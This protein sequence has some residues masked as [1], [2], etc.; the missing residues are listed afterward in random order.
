ML[1][2]LLHYRHM[3]CPLIS[4]LLFLTRDYLFENTKDK[5]Y[6]SFK[7]MPCLRLVNTQ[8]HL[9]DMRRYRLNNDVKTV[10]DIYRLW[11][12]NGFLLQASKYI[13]YDTS[14]GDE[15]KKQTK[16]LKIT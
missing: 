10:A 15:E 2:C 1:A 8:G 5:S 9:R 7:E 3:P 11:S 12:T 14:F 4:C 13:E 6:I 16:A